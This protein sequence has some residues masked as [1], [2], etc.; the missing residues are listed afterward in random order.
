MNVLIIGANGKVGKH[1]VRILSNQGHSVSAMIRSEEQ[2][3][4]IREL[5]GN[6]ILGNLEEEISTFFF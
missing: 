2:A 4:A 3:Q 6:P 5:G 1:L